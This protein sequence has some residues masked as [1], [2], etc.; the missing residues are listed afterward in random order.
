MSQLVVG[1]RLEVSFDEE[2]SEI[3]HKETRELILKSKRK[4]EMYP[5]DMKL[6]QGKP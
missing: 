4:G 5:F 2:G 6:I 1:I 3:I